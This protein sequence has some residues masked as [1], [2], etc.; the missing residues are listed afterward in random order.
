M[1]PLLVAGGVAL[2]EVEEALLLGAEESAVLGAEEAVVGA[3]VAVVGAEAALDVVA[4][5]VVHPVGAPAA[6][7]QQGPCSLHLP[8]LEHLEVDVDEDARPT[9]KASMSL[10]VQMMERLLQALKQFFQAAR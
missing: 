9:M 10:R 8:L 3:E 5:P 7:D 1:V 4:W 6:V 2:E